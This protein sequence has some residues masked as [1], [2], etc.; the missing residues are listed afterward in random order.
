MIR[1]LFEKKLN[2][3][4]K[5]KSYHSWGMYA[6]SIRNHL[7][8]NMTSLVKMRNQIVNPMKVKNRLQKYQSDI[9]D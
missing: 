7:E 9:K 6:M 1:I 4:K 8:W 3:K 2:T 5:V